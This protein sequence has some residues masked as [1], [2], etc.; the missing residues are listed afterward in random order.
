MKGGW[1]GNLKVRE[2]KGGD[3]AGV[4][5][6]KNQIFTWGAESASA[7]SAEEVGV[8]GGVGFVDEL[9]VRLDKILGP[10]QVTVRGGLPHVVHGLLLGL[11]GVSH[12][13]R[14]HRSPVEVV[15]PTVDQL[16]AP[17]LEI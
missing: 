14:E 15:D 4:E 16:N 5:K 8:P 17:S 12:W 6:R 7:G 10:V 3:R 2:R 11:G 1:N 13:R 9:R